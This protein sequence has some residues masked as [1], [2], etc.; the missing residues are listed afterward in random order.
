MFLTVILEAPAAFLNNPLP[1]SPTPRSIIGVISSAPIRSGS[2]VRVSARGKLCYATNRSHDHQRNSR[3][4]IRLAGGVVEGVEGRL[5]DF[6]E[7]A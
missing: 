3:R 5:G 4:S 2:A 7:D 1:A 6:V